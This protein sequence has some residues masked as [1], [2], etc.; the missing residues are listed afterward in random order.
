M[1]TT[2]T[3]TDRNTGTLAKLAI[4]AA[5]VAMAAAAAFAP[6][7]SSSSPA[8]PYIL[9]PG[10]QDVY[11]GGAGTFSA[12]IF[13]GNW[14]AVVQFTAGINGKRY[15]TR[16]VYVCDVKDSARVTFKVRPA[17]LGPDGNYQYR[18]K[19]GRHDA[20][21]D[22]VRWTHGLTGTFTLG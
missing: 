7:A 20:D 14:K 5:L 19:V 11:R 10:I 3:L 16:T 9:E 8:A 2:H 18:I 6:T 15:V 13:C 21:G 17:Q 12:D 22:V 4:L 1:S